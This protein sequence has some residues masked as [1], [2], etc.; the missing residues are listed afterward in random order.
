MASKDDEAVPYDV[1]TYWR[2]LVSSYT[3]LN[4]IE[5]GQLN[6]VDFLRYRHD[7]FIQRCASTKEGRD[8]L[9]ECWRM[10][11]T[12]PDRGKLR[13]ITGKEGPANGQ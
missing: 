10:E 12:K 1:E 13:R 7:A 6:Y 4:F 2:Y 3:G 5:I 8:F 11:Q 9:H